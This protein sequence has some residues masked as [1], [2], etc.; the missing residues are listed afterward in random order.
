MNI[1][2][3]DGGQSGTRICL[4]PGPNAPGTFIELP[5][6]TRLNDPYVTIPALVRDALEHLQHPG[7]ER[8]VLGLT[9]APNDPDELGR[10]AQGLAEAARAQEV[11][12]ADD[13]ITTHAAAFTGK[14]GV[15][16][17]LGTGTAC[18]AVAPDRVGRR[19]RRFDGLG[20][21]LGDLGSAFDIGRR[22]LAT[23]L[24]AWDLGV[25]PTSDL[26]DHVIAKFGPLE[27]LAVALHDSPTMIQQ[28]AN[29]APVVLE[30]AGDR[31]AD[32]IIAAVVRDLAATVQAATQ[33]V[34][35]PAPLVVGGRLFTGSA[36]LQGALA[37]ELGVEEV[38]CAQ[39]SALDG[40]VWLGHHDDPGVYSDEIYRWGR[41][42]G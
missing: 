24:R 28:V 20:F 31:V 1:L 35:A 7:V 4:S 37:A 14:Q 23:V 27:E 19:C 42:N 17:W 15:S 10:L 33:W 18:F 21:L 41:Q 8:V 26:H 11:W 29:F 32:Q 12:I 38:Q 9:T 30:H 16:L 3:V 25:A 5:G 13:T 22:A 6:V 36:V 2:A 34:G 40:S 39:S